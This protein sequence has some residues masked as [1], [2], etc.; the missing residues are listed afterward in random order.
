M[1]LAGA[2]AVYLS[3][4][5]Q[6]LPHDLQYLGMTPE[7][8]CAIGDCRIVHFMFHNRVSLGGSVIAVGVL[9]LWLIRFPLRQG[10]AWAWWLLL[11]SGIVGFGSFF[12]YLGHGYMDTWHA[13][14]LLVLVPCFIFGLAR[15]FLPSGPGSLLRSSASTSRLGRA[16]L[17]LSALGLF[18]AGLVIMAVG[19]TWVFVPEDL[20]YL[21]MRAEEMH[22][23]SPRLVPLISHDRASFGGGVCTTGLV[24]F[25]CVWCG[26][27]SRALWQ[28][29]AIAGFA[30]FSTAI[31]VHPLIGYLD[32][33]HLAPAVAGAAVFAAGLAM[34]YERR[35]S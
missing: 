35:L 21:R 8:L 22:A 3:I 6:F 34:T 13:I 27:P 18:L 30:G 31:A 9:W 2:F 20:G 4:T 29:L 10:E 11:A 14:V 12:T 23:I 33:V 5:Y 15:T 28:A 19:M 32:F 24:M 26:R 25:F 16:C 1:I 7:A 17:L